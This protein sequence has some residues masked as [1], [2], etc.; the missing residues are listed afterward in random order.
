MVKKFLEEYNKLLWV[1]GRKVAGK[2]YG[3]AIDDNLSK[4]ELLG[5]IAIL[6]EPLRDPKKRDEIIKKDKNAGFLK[7]AALFLRELDK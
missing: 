5:V 1:S 3:V 2:M 6:T 4:K 7:K